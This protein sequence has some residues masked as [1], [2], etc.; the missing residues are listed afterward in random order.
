MEYINYVNM[1][2][3][4][5]LV[6][7]IWGVEN[8]DLA[9]PVNNALV[10]RTSFLAADTQP[11]VLKPSAAQNNIHQLNS[12]DHNPITFAVSHSKPIHS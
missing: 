2:E 7:E 3:I 5:P 1:I 9:V 4:G 10:C 6:I 11:C 12:S 8:G